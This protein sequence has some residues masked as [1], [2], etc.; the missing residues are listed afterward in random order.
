MDGAFSVFQALYGVPQGSI[1]GPSLYI[2]YTTPLSTAIPNSSAN[3]H[4]YANYR[5]TQRFLSSSAAD[6]ILV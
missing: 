4:L 2:L 6:V 3:H 1:R 5:F